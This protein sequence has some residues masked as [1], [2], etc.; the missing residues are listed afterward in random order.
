MK[1]R[2]EKRVILFVK[3]TLFIRSKK[4][5]RNPL[6]QTFFNNSNFNEIFKRVLMKPLTITIKFLGNFKGAS[7]YT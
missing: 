4:I 7:R 6:Y 1:K 5:K 2:K 3:H